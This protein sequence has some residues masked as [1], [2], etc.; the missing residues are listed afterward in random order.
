MEDFQ[1]CLLELKGKNDSG[2]RMIVDVHNGTFTP[3]LDKVDH[4]T[5]IA[6]S[7]HSTL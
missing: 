6:S 4:S 2:D 7:T 1:P 3:K 5:T